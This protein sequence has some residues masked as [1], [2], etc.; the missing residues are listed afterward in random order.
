[1]IQ[2]NRGRKSV[3]ANI[4]APIGGWNA[5][6][7]LAEM[8]PTEAVA[9]NNWWPTTVDLEERKG[10]VNWATGM[11]GTVETIIPYNGVTGVDRLFAFTSTGNIHDVTSPNVVGAALVT[12]LSNG[13]WQHVA[14]ATPGGNFILAC[15]GVDNMRRYDGTSWT[16]IGA[17][18]TG[19]AS[20]TIISL[21]AFKGRV[22]MVQKD[23]LNMWYLPTLAIAGA[24]TL[25]P[26]GS[27]FQMGGFLRTMATWTV[28]AGT[29]AD[30]NAVFIT[31]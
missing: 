13:R 21:N 14:F 12:G 19:V 31:D 4:P 24:A 11:T 7:S 10:F 28:D 26:L 27:V 9:I 16:D 23:T 5:R 20:T 18:I 15:N 30:D 2:V 1:M 8:L 29:G 17:S 22:W 6:D 25:F 3:T